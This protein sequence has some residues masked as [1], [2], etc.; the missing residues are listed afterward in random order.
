MRIVKLHVY[1]PDPIEPVWLIKEQD[2][3]L[4]P[5]SKSQEYL[6]TAV[7]LLIPTETNSSTVPSFNS[8]T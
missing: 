8:S 6:R 1:P 3:T 2:F 4:L 5:G 7:G